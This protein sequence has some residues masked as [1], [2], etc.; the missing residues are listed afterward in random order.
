MINGFDPAT[1]LQDLVKILP[2]L[3]LVFYALATSA[4]PS[5]PVAP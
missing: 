3:M 5:W 1:V 4:R 2:E